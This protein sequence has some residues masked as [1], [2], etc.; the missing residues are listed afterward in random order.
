VPLAISK[1]HQVD[2]A[3]LIVEAGAAGMIPS[4]ELS[5]DRLA[6]RLEELLADGARL[7][8]MGRAARAL[9]H[10]RAVA[11]IADRVEELREAR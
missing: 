5:A 8:A 10:P 11:D 7:A 2:N 4:N 1:G 6:A 9:A 3:R